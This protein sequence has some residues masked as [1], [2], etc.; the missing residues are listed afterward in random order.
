MRACGSGRCAL[1]FVDRSQAGNRRWCSMSRCGNRTKA[2]R[3][4]LR[5]RPAG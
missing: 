2:R 5:T 3:H 1:R 4:H